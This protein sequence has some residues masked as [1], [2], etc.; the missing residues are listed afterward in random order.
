MLAFGIAEIAVHSARIYILTGLPQVIGPVSSKHMAVV[1]NKVYPLV[2]LCTEYIQYTIDNTASCAV[3]EGTDDIVLAK[4]P[5]Q[6]TSVRPLIHTKL[7]LQ[8][9]LLVS[10]VYLAWSVFLHCV[11]EWS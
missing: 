3:L 9:V 4:F 8:L 11:Q 1:G 7:T 5:S 6:N 10:G 2:E